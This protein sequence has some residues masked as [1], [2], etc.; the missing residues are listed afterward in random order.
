MYK[1]FVL[2]IALTVLPAVAYSETYW[3]GELP[4]VKDT[5]VEAEVTLNG[6]TYS[7]SYT[8]HSGSGNTGN[9]WIF[10]IDIKQP[11]GGMKLSMD[12]ADEPSIMAE[13]TVPVKLSRPGNWYPGLDYLSTAGWGGSLLSP[14]QSLTGLQMRSPGLP[15]IREFRI[16]PRL[17]PAPMESNIMAVVKATRKKASFF[18][19]T[20]GPTAPP[21]DSEGAFNSMALL[22]KIDGYVNESVSLGWLTDAALA[23]ALRAKLA[24]AVQFME[25]DDG[26][27]A[28][29]KLIE[30][31]TLLDNSTASQRTSEVYGL[32]Y[33]NAKYVR[34]YL[35]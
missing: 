19:K 32:L 22:K 10:H 33:Y 20:I 26:T 25:A 16:V 5:A 35:K 18:A 8:V 1:I 12:G 11:Q 31:I 7:Y 34:D 9:I 2:L 29:A 21:V 3:G 30:F 27:Q 15:G 13:P 17:A 28:K 6:D 23:D 14:G 24:A 4:Y